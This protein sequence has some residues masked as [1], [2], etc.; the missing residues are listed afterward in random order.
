MSGFRGAVSFLTRVPVADGD[1]PVLRRSI[2]WFPV[3]GA[4]VGLGAA[5]V[6]AAARVV[7]APSV[8]A[9]L[10]VGASAI[11]T[12][13]L[14]EDGLADTADALGGGSSPEERVRILKDPRHG[15]FG[16]LAIV[17]SVVV[18]IAS[19][20][21]MS[22]WIALAFLPAAH[23]LSRTAA[24]SALGWAPRATKEGSAAAFADHVTRRSAF[25]AS[26]LAVAIGFAFVGLAGVPAAVLAA[27]G[28][29]VVASLGIRMV[30]GVTGDLLGAI[31]QVGETAILVLGAAAAHA[32]W[33]GAPWWP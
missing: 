10:S 29:I 23:S 25:A 11:A 20:A 3:V 8:A 7:V 33:R 30:G 5:G 16:V 32:A 13:A 12:G 31:E 18:R 19:V 9:A 21:S 27:L 15:T 6:Y 4:L 2:P 24:V 17:L 22:G 28:A 1:A 14:H 26:A